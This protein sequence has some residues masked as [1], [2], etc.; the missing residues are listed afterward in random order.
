MWEVLISSVPTFVMLLFLPETSG[1]CILYRRAAQLRRITGNSNIKTKQDASQPHLSPKQL[2][3]HSFVIPLKITIMDPAML[4]TNLYMAL[5]YSIFY[6][7]FECFPLT[8][9]EIYHFNLG[10]MGCTFLSWAIG[11]VIAFVTYNIYL[12]TAWVPTVKRNDDLG[13]QED[14]L[15][16]ALLGSLLP[17]IGLLLF[18]WTARPDIHWIISQIGVVIYPAGIFVLLQ[19]LFLY[20]SVSYPQ[21]SA[22]LLGLSEFTRGIFACVA[23]VIARPLFLNLGLGPACSLLAGLT[24]ICVGGI[25]FLYHYG[26]ALRKRS[27]FIEA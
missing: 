16:P 12:Y 23:V 26:E 2:I 18:G 9:Q 15:K 14:Y 5:V 13:K 21:Y 27:R 7:F 10:E 4:F 17:P 20:I 11:S 22:S 25:F 3:F 1:P 8:Y 24:S 19:T 6:S